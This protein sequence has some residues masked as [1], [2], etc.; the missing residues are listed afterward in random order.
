MYMIQSVEDMDQ[1]SLQFTLMRLNMTLVF[2]IID[3]LCL[4]VAL[5]MIYMHKI[6]YIHSKWPLMMEILILALLMPTELIIAVLMNF[7]LTQWTVVY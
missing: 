6:T 5:A 1:V 2:I 3:G 7:T 4:I